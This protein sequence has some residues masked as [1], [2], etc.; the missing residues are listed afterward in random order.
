ML[1]IDLLR[2][3][4]LT[5]EAFLASSSEGDE[6]ELVKAYNIIKDFPKSEAFKS[7]REEFIAWANSFTERNKKFK[8]KYKNAIQSFDEKSFV[9][10][11]KGTAN[12]KALVKKL[13]EETL[14]IEL[15]ALRE[16]FE[17]ENFNK[18]IVDKCREKIFN[19]IE[20]GCGEDRELLIKFIRNVLPALCLNDKRWY[21][22]F[23]WE[24]RTIVNDNGYCFFS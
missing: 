6:K 13:A 19:H 11:P 7:E 21:N 20:G 10:I 22:Q 3:G 14:H 2:Y 24:C 12:R 15:K 17:Q 4:H 16:E 18:E 9:L 1:S 5:T 23:W 8:A